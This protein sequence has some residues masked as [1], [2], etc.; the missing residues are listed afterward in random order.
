MITTIQFSV[1]KTTFYDKSR[2]FKIIGDAFQNH[3]ECYKKL[4]SKL[5][6]LL[7]T[8]TY[9]F[10]YIHS[11]RLWQNIVVITVFLSKLD[12]KTLFNYIYYGSILVG[13]L[14]SI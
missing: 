7:F 4:A 5:W 8:L 12:H 2:F 13:G 1:R 3:C 10:F 11:P 6:P 9:F 14:I